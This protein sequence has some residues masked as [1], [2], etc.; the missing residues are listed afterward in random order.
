MPLVRPD[1]HR[2]PGHQRGVRVIPRGDVKCGQGGDV[3]GDGV[4]NRKSLQGL[5]T[6]SQGTSIGAG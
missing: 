6:A 5:L 4:A 3:A 2:W 1:R